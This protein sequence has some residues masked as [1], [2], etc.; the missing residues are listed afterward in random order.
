[1]DA[2]AAK[3]AK[4]TSTSTGGGSWVAS[5]GRRLAEVGKGAEMRLLVGA[6]IESCYSGRKAGVGVT[7][8]GRGRCCNF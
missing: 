7:P 6:R 2:A 4:S 1:M 5:G 8:R 3:D